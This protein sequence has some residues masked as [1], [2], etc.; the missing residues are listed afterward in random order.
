MGIWV[1]KYLQHMCENQSCRRFFPSG[2]AFEIWSEFKSLLQNPW[3]NSSFEGSG[4]ARLFLPMNVD[5]QDFIHS[6]KH[7]FPSFFFSF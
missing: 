3:H 6:K 2:S 5:N 4:F 7:I 1:L